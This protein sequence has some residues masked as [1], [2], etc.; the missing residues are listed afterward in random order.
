MSGRGFTGGRDWNHMNSR[1]ILDSAAYRA[2]EMLHFFT[3]FS[4]SFGANHSW[5]REGTRS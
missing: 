4:D 3:A 1:N 2:E 5:A